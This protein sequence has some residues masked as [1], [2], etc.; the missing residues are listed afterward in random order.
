MPTINF[1]G[2]NFVANHHL[3]VPHH[4]LIPVPE[5]SITKEGRCSL[6]DNLIVHGDNLL[7]LKALLPTYA[8]KVD[9]IYI[10]PPYNTGIES[11][12][13][14]DNVNSPM[15]QEWL[16]KTVDTEDLTRH[17]KWLCMMM[18]RL[19]LLAELL[20]EDGTIF[21]SCDDNELANLKVLCD[22]IFG[23]ENFIEVFSWKKTLSPSN[24]S[25][26]T[27]KSL[28]YI[29][30]YEKNRNSK[31]FTGLVKTSDA[32]NPL[33][34]K[35]NNISKLVFKSSACF[36]T[37]TEDV[38]LQPGKYGTKENEV[39]LHN[40]VR[41]QNGI[42]LDDL[43]L[44]SNFV[45]SQEYLDNEIEGGTKIIFKKLKSLAPRY[46]KPYYKPE[47]PRNLIDEEDYVGTTEDGGAELK[48]LKLNGVI[49]YPKPVDTIKYIVSMVANKDSIILD[50]F[51]GSG[52][53]AHAVLELNK[54]DGGNR[55]FILVETEDYANTLTAERV[56]RVMRGVPESKSFQEPLGGTFSFFRLGEPIKMETLLDGANLP[57]FTEMARYLYY[58]STGEQPDMTKF[59]EVTGYLGESRKYHIYLLY[60]PDLEYLKQTAL[61][62]QWLQEVPPPYLKTQ[63]KTLVFAPAKFVDEDTLADY[64]ADF[65]QLPFEIYKLSH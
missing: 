11:W 65:C 38:T 4:E 37:S 58:T 13:Y 18:P 33:I 8:G 30:C 15:I 3:G 43:I 22:E 61:T 19:K 36:C 14:N 35:N 50:S 40:V 56:R 44:E 41:Y 55:K 59:N 2:K 25:N 17:D 46:D 24:L 53:T 16:G 6:H 51:A 1:K 64:T 7:A 42:F 20:S 29:I 12:I 45:W 57:S 23:E 26:K 49:D 10:D 32:D 27:K 54:E 52:T 63:K 31:R 9:V 34:K 28:E 62:L 5:H 60:K 39:I 47:V 21:M 48:D